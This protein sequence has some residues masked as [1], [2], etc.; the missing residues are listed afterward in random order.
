MTTATSR[1]TTTTTKIAT[2][3]DG[4]NNNVKSMNTLTMNKTTLTLTKLT[5]TI[6]TTGLGVGRIHAK[7]SGKRN[8]K[9]VWR[10][11]NKAGYTA[12]LVAC[13]WA[14]AAFEFLEHLGRS[15]EGKDRKNIKK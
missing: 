13:G 5:T 11:L 2:T 4:D 6:S 10:S 7:R 14:R 1:T 12:T 3:S 15:S 9:Y 8:T